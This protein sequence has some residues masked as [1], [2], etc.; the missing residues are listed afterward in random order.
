MR[1]SEDAGPSHPGRR[2]ADAKQCLDFV[3][4][5]AWR[6]SSTPEER[7][8]SPAAVLDWCAKAGL[9]RP[10]DAAR[11]AG[12]AAAVV[13][14]RTALDFRDATYRLLRARVDG[15]PGRD[16]DLAA[17][18]AVMAAMPQ[19]SALVSG[20]DGPGWHDAARPQSALDMLAPLVWSAADLLSGP[21]AERVKQ[22]ADP[23]GCGWLFL[24]ES[25]TGT[26]RWCSMGDCGNR[27]K[28]RRHYERSRAVAG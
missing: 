25:R 12:D 19:R 28:A 4:T 6:N 5:V 20:P 3:N 15:K 11:L 22:C 23:K 7:L 26:R 9:L 17:L 24:D 21:R 13:L 1:K 2:S 14:H 27:A 16:A 8:T 18:N 10:G